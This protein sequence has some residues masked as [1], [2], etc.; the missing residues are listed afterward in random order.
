M[1]VRT[2]VRLQNDALQAENARLVYALQAEYAPFYVAQ[3][4]R[5]LGALGDPPEERA[6]GGSAARGVRSYFVRPGQTER[7]SF[8]LEAVVQLL[9]EDDEEGTTRGQRETASNAVQQLQGYERGLREALTYLFPL[10]CHQQPFVEAEGSSTEEALLSLRHVITLLQG[11]R[12][13]AEE[14]KTRSERSAGIKSFLDAEWVG[15]KL[16]TY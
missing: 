15:V 4:D 11:I 2:T 12:A 3:C 10:Y 14:A 8:D 9:E 5:A 13:D 16:L 1:K 7:A 6:Q